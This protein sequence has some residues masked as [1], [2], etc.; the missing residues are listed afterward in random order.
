M[1]TMIVMVECKLIISKISHILTTNIAWCARITQIF[2]TVFRV[3]LHHKFVAS[4]AWDDDDG[5]LW[6]V[7]P[8]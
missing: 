5:A 3:T 7:S 6:Q 8:S 4:D 1:I 2:Q